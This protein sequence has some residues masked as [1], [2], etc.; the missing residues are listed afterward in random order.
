MKYDYDKVADRYD[1]FRA[2]GGPYLP[3]LVSLARAWSVECALEVGAGTGNNTAPF[4]AAHPC[5]LVA[6]DISRGMLR[7]A[8]LKDIEARWLQGDTHHL[9]LADRSVDMVFGCYMLHYVQD[10]DRM[11]GEA[12]RVLRRGG[13][14]FVTASH[15]FIERHPM[16]AYF[17]SFSRIDK[18][19]FPSV[20]RLRDALRRAGFRDIEQSHIAADPRPIDSAF[21]EQV[22][23]HF[24]S[25]YALLPEDEFNAGLARLRADV[26]A[27]GRLDTSLVWESVTVWGSGPA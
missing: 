22:A 13:A 6:L 11:L 20:E 10:L 27:R 26:E 7:R 3:V 15:D 1:R 24:I 19:R 8:R 18:A 12:A 2:G 9:P 14:A 16:N 17:P 4:H 5:R 21:V 25:T 23:N